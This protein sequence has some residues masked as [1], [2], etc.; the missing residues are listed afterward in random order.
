MNKAKQKIESDD[1]EVYCTT[2]EAADLLH[3]SLRTVQL[4]VE[5]GVLKAWKT[6]GG[7]RR[8]PLSSVKE[9]IQERMNKTGTVPP[10]AARSGNDF[11]IL[12][13]EDDED[14]LKLYRLTMAA[15]QMPIQLTF[16]S[17]VFEA[18]VVIGRTPPDL[19]ITDLRISGVDGFEIIRLLRNDPLLRQLNIVV[20]TGMEPHEIEARG[21]LPN[22]ITQF[23][24]PISFD[25][26]QGYIKACLAHRLLTCR[27][28]K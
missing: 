13:L 1:T 18:L 7:H 6:D 11:N 21:G 10:V 14:T 24:K 3:V 26:L 23:S 5:S 12:I 2:R 19:L 27:Q 17:S 4:W 28:E 8:L 16:V 25:Q 20:V 15:W 22:D 9:L